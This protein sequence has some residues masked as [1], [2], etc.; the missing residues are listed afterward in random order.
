MQVVNQCVHH[1]TGLLCMLLGK[2]IYYY[3]TNVDTTTYVILCVF[4]AIIYSNNVET[5]CT[6]S[7]RYVHVTVAAIDKS[8]VQL[9]YVQLQ[10]NW[11]F[12]ILRS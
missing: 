7:I 11:M 9:L 10:Y 1:L 8:A 12:M 3:C 6:L 5:V 4:C 2:Y